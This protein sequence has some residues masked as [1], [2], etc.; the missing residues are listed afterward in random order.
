[1]EGQEQDEFRHGDSSTPAQIDTSRSTLGQ[2]KVTRRIARAIFLGSAA[3]LRAAHKGIER[4]SIWQGV[5]V[6]GDTV[7]N[8]GPHCSCCPTSD[9]L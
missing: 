2:R 9:Q 3:T 6:P 7:G 1:M 5:A 4:P 8:F